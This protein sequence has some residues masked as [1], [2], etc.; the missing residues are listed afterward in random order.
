MEKID[1]KFTGMDIE[2]III[3]LK[4]GKRGFLTNAVQVALTRLF[5]KDALMGMDASF[6]ALFL[7][8]ENK[9]RILNGES[10]ASISD[11]IKKKV[12]S[13]KNPKVVLKDDGS[14]EK[15]V[16]KDEGSATKNV[17]A[18][19]ASKLGDRVDKK[20]EDIASPSDVVGKQK[21]PVK[22]D[23]NANPFYMDED[24]I[25]GEG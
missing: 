25:N 21:E 2:A 13:E 10:L 19:D 3:I 6:T 8:D 11:S 20:L 7:S 5:D 24:D 14:N 1:L 22:I 9:N 12:S 15:E 16:K 23:F 4:S 17:E 18:M